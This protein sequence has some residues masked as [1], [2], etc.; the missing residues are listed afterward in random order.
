MARKIDLPVSAFSFFRRKQQYHLATQHNSVAVSITHNNIQAVNATPTAIQTSFTVA[1]RLKFSNELQ[2]TLQPEKSTK[3]AP[4]H[5][6]KYCVHKVMQFQIRV[7]QYSSR[8]HP[9]PCLRSPNRTATWHSNQM[10]IIFHRNPIL[11]I[12]K[13]TQLTL[14]SLFLSTCWDISNF[15]NIHPSSRG[16]MI[17]KMEGVLQYNTWEI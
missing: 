4:W 16:E 5:P 1:S 8:E 15:P 17:A 11:T 13:H 6:M 2:S 10:S 14:G 7:L 12:V 3:T 9:Y